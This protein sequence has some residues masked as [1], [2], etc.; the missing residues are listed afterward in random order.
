MP[1]EIESL[2]AFDTVASD[3]AASLR[4][5]RVQSVDLHQRQQALRGLDVTSALFLGCG[6]DEAVADNLR[7]RGALVFPA[8][9]DVPFDAYRNSLYTASEL[10]DRIAEAPYEDC[11][12]AVVYAWARSVERAGDVAAALA[13][14]LHDSAIEDALDDLLAA[15]TI[16]GDSLVGVMG[17][18]ATV[19]GD[20][21][22][23]EAARLGRE[24]TRAGYTVATGGGPGAMEAANLGA[25]LADEDVSALDSAA[26]ALGAVP[27]FHP[28]PTDWARRAAGVLDRHP[29]GHLSLGVP[30]WFYGHEPPN[31]FATAIAKYF[32]NPLRE[33]VLLDRCHGGV[34][35]LEGAAGTVQEIFTDACE[36]YYAP[37][38]SV[39]PMVLVGLEYWQ[40]R[41]PAWPL[42]QA[43]AVDRPMA[44]RIRCVATAGEAVAALRAP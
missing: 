21:A 2:A 3:A 41:L 13:K 19:R 5:A 25:Y 36:N 27:S 16:D 42:L 12:D 43:L 9:P 11:Y 39:R 26:S 44:Q 14:A 1:V 35:F 40:Q 15:H 24:L 29:D 22:F 30:T 17:G 18:H 31:L 34:V 37:A 7:S 28:S 23:V 32:A 20:Q 4:G 38:T 8:I 33:A 10:Y 6:L